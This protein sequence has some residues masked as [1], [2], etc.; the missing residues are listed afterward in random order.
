MRAVV[1]GAG[2]G[3]LA[4]ALSL[5]E[6]GVDVDVYE[7]TREIK[8]LGVGVNLLPHAVKELHE[9]GLEAAL[10]SAGVA[11]SEL[12]YYSKRG[13]RIWAE[14]RGL[15]AGYRWPQ[16]S[17]HRGRLQ[18]LL[19]DAV[20][21]RLGSA[22]VHTG[23][24]LA[25]F[26]EPGDRVRCRFVERGTGEVTGVVEGDVL[27][28][29]DGIHSRVRAQLHPGEGDPR[30]SGALMWRGVTIGEPFLGGRSM[31]MAGHSSQKFVCYSIG[32]AGAGRDI[33][34]W[35]AE[36]HFERA[37]PIAREDWS[38]PGKVEDFLSRFEGWRFGWLD[39][40]A[41]VLR[42]EAIFVYPMVD[43]DPLP[44]WGSGR[45]TLLGDAAHPMYPIGSNGA[46]QA[47][48]DARV[49]AG[50]MRS[51]PDPVQ[52][53]RRYEA[54]RRPATEAIVLANRRQGPEECMTL[55]E[56]RAPNGFENIADVVSVDELT[57]IAQKYK[58]VAGFAVAEL[59]ERPS[60]AHV[61]Y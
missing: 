58:Q 56:Q 19:L 54:V 48:L 25:G 27:V 11:P 61:P 40:P 12:A 5:H 36:L 14:P 59:N 51:Y 57:A 43:R 24:H 47:I 55:V 60:L 6:C 49:L 29:C 41:L 8:P 53:L 50:C 46:S 13:Q 22:R 21:E 10:A 4:T 15:E 28:A 30:W 20:R 32:H 18:M 7:S 3:G 31:I 35:I 1:V 38:S 33:L 16:V 42:A 23:C 17:I 52:A 34:N 45:V 2:I 37:T 26:D 39:V 44:A 9:L